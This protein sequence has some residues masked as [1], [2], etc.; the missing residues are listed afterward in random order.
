MSITRTIKTWLGTRPCG[1]LWGALPALLLGLA[2][3]AFGVLLLSSHP[4]RTRDYYAAVATKALA[5]RDFKTA[6]VASQRHLLS[7]PNAAREQTGYELSQAL[8]GLGQDQAGGALLNLAA[9]LDQPG[10]APAQLLLA[11]YLLSQTKVTEPL[12]QQAELHLNYALDQTNLASVAHEMLGQLQFQRGEWAAART[13]LL[14]AVDTQPEAGL[15]LAIIARKA[16]DTNEMEHWSGVALDYYYNRVTKATADDPPARLGWAQTLSIR[17][18]YAEA[19][20]LLEAGVKQ[21]GVAVY[22]PALAELYA[23]WAAKLAREEPENLAPWLELLRQGLVYQPQDF[24]LL[25]PLLALSSPGA[26]A[27]TPPAALT[28]V[29]TNSEVAP[30]AHLLLANDAA[31]NGDAAEATREFTQAL[32]PA[33]DLKVVAN[34]LILLLVL[35]KQPDLPRALALVQ[36]LV[37]AYPSQPDFRNT[38][39]QIFAAQGKWADAVDDLEYA[40]PLVRDPAATHLALARVYHN[41]GMPALAAE[42]ERLARPPTNPTASGQ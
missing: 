8:L 16:G 40:L 9:P 18:N 15:M 26:A 34:N 7:W 10:Y 27:T 36:P 29:L 32:E 6:R 21:S 37:A 39:G 3:A 24:R 25:E 14:A 2:W 42:H 38:R 30:L 33:P 4:A 17:E 13:N 23:Y 35:T 22:A 11:R 20:Q 28:N 19:I 5:T 12:R 31:E 41:L 1:E